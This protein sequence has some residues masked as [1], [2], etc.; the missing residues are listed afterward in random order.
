MSDVELESALDTY[1]ACL[2]LMTED[3]LCNAAVLAA[4]EEDN[5]VMQTLLEKRQREGLTSNELEQLQCL[6]E[7]FNQ[8]MMTRA[9]A[10]AILHERGYD[11]SAL[12]HIHE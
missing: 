11:I 5:E 2:F 6:S 1:L 7:R 3:E 9:R 10:A 4:S 8:I 12:A